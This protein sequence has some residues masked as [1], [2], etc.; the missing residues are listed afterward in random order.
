MATAT[1]KPP[2]TTPGPITVCKYCQSKALE[3]RGE[4]TRRDIEGVNPKT[5][6]HYV[7]II[8]RHLHCRDCHRKQPAKQFIAPPTRRRNASAEKCAKSAPTLRKI[9]PISV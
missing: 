9:A 1:Q 3:E 5:G 2:R 4:P 6:E 8:W 7:A